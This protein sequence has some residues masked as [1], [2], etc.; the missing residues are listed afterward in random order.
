MPAQASLTATSELRLGLNMSTLARFSIG[1]VL[2]HLLAFVGDGE[3]RFHFAGI[4]RE[5]PSVRGFLTI[6]IRARNCFV[7]ALVGY[8]TQPIKKSIQEPTA[9]RSMPTGL[10]RGDVL[11]THGNTRVAA[12]ISRVT[13]SRWSHVSMYVGPLEDGPDPVCIVEA[14]M[15]AGVRSIRFSELNVSRGTNEPRKIGRRVRRL[16][17]CV[18]K[19]AALQFSE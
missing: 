10:N 15:A 14:D 8:L 4:L 17:A 3:F 6:L 5:L 2:L 7:D 1:R 13:R 12:L 18:D 16:R 19:V 11:L 9:D